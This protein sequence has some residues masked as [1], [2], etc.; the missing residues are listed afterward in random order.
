MQTN[1]GSQTAH[2]PPSCLGPWPFARGPGSRSVSI[3]IPRCGWVFAAVFVLALAP[4]GV[5]GQGAPVAAE[6]SR[7]EEIRTLVARLQS[8]AVPP[9]EKANAC[10]RLAIIGTKDAVPAL[11]AMLSDEKLA[12]LARAALEPMPDPAA[13][14]ALR[15][16]LGQLQGKLLV[17]AINSVG[18]RRDGRATA[19]LAGLLAHADTQ[20]AA[21]AAAALGRIGTGE[22]AQ[23]LQAALASAPAN[24]RIT[25]ADAC[26]TCAEGLGAAQPGKEAAAIYD[27]LCAGGFPD[28]VRTAAMRGAIAVRGAGGVA[29]LVQQLEGD[30]QAMLAAAWGAARVLPG[31]SVTAALAA[32]LPSLPVAKQVLLLHVLA[33]RA[34]KAALPV[35]IDAAR[36]AT[37][38]VRLAAIQAVPR[39]DANGASLPILLQA[40][41]AGQNPAEVDAAVVSLGQIGGADTNAKILA[42][43]GTAAPANRARLIT[44]L[45][46]RRAETA[47]SQ[48]MKYAE[49]ADPEVSKAA[50]RALALVG[51]PGDLPE[52]IRLSTGCRDEALKVPADLAV[53]GVAMKI[54]PATQRADPV[55]KALRAATT[56]QAKCSLL[57]PLGA[58]VKAMGSSPQAFDTVKSALGDSDAQVRDTALRCLAEWPDASPAPLLLDLAKRDPANRTLA[59]RGGIRM[60]ANVAAGRD[61]TS[62]AVLAWF[63][64]AN[65][66]VRT[67]DEKLMI[68]SGL[69]SLKRIE[70][71]RM[72]QP[73]LDDSAVKTEAALAVV[74]IAPALAATKDAADLRR[75]L[76]QI[77][78]STEDADVRRKA[79][80]M[81]KSLPKKGA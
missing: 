60:A 55:V 68:V 18:F 36:A 24:R 22:A 64:E 54:E 79:G 26:L 21:A 28:Y 73:Y 75:V 80:K 11:A 52:L 20:V 32:E 48:L 49:G 57:R 42:A 39:L 61:P 35:A 47:R 76:D 17:G 56:P 71:L 31:S 3:P 63:I 8:P 14:A 46:V 13:A 2:R 1:L 12:H 23:R 15:D 74:E 6:L 77:V 44:V 9:E 59:L 45:G 16:A 5:S 58:I 10:R 4:F 27:R 69:G 40:I 50:F 37:A 38:E 41:A 81:A 33:E 34:D 66:L 19:T 25:L 30:D 78:R 67:T 62:L 7:S 53:F 51:R 43:L 65:Q 72:L 70:G 29:L